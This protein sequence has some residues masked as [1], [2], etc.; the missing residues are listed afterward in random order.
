MKELDREKLKKESTVIKKG[1]QGAC[2]E[3]R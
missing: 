2:T 3:G 1:P